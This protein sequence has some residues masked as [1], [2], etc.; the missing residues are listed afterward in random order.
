MSK[1]GRK[2]G[3]I[4]WNKGIPMSEATKKRVSKAKKGTPAWNKGKKMSEAMREKML[5]N[6]N[7]HGNKG[8]KMSKAWLKKLSLAKLGKPSNAK[9]RIATPEEKSQKSITKRAQLLR[10]NS[11]YDY[12]LDTKTRQG[13]KRV[14]R[15]RL[16]KFGGSHTALQWEELKQKYGFTCSS[17]KRPEP[18]IK[19]TRDH[20][21]SLSNGGTDDIGNIQP[22]CNSC[23]ARKSTKTIRY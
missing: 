8:R 23:N 21:I 18:E 22:L 15:E 10:D 11:N 12:R 13:N 16:K 3:S 19:L 17:C 5:G 6:T 7:G 1:S 14:R 9:G 4:P 20:I 2:K